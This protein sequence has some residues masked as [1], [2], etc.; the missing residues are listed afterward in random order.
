[1]ACFQFHDLGS[2]PYADVLELQTTAFDKLV[3][4]KTKGGGEKNHLFFCEHEPVLTIGKHGKESNLLIPES[5]LREKG[6]T[7][8][9]VSRG[10]DITYHGPGQIT[11]YPVFDLECWNMGLRQYI[12][13]LEEIM[14]RF[15]ALYGLKGERLDGATGVWLDPLVK[16]RARKICA[17]GVRSSHFVTMHGFALNINTDLSY[18][19][20]I[21]PCGFTDKGV[22]SLARELGE[23]Q[24]FNLAKRQL[25]E[26]FESFF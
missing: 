23:E 8:Y 3:D 11:G 13:N 4:S 20:Y 12:Y 7:F 21:N 17:I 2:I 5:L 22:T 15:L 25:R 19:S 10:G 14:I 6:I 9:H 1:M 24:D 18:F 26:L 16:G